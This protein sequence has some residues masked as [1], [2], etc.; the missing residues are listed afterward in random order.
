MMGTKQGKVK[1]IPR[2][3]RNHEM[4]VRV[5]LFPSMLP[6]SKVMPKTIRAID[7]MAQIGT[8]GTILLYTRR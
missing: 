3:K 1:I 6:W 5:K 8:V 4:R 7:M 2:A